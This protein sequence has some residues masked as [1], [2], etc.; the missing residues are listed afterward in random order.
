MEILEKEVT[1]WPNGFLECYFT[2]PKENSYDTENILKDGNSDLNFTKTNYSLPNFK[3]QNSVK[4]KV[5][6]LSFMYCF[7]STMC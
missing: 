6:L 7:H 1:V 2:P 5:D 3:V 4:K